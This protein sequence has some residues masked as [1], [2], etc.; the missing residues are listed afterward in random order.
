MEEASSG[1]S[2]GHLSR[3]FRKFG[4]NGWLKRVTSRVDRRQTLLSL[5]RQGAAA[6]RSME[7]RSDEQVQEMLHSTL[8]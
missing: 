2:C 4:K 6:L 8:Q 1:V 7:V 5:T 3:I